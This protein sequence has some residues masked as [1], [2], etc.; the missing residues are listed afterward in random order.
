MNKE[1]ADE[2]VEVRTLSNLI[3]AFQRR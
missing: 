2:R 3:R 1:A